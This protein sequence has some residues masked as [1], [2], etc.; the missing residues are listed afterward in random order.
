MNTTCKRLPAQST[1]VLHL[2]I[3]ARRFY[4]ERDELDRLLR[5][6]AKVMDVLTQAL[7]KFPPLNVLDACGD[8]R[9]QRLRV[10]DYGRNNVLRLAEALVI[11]NEIDCELVASLE[12]SKCVESIA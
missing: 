3:L 11:R 4:Q 9:L 2:L 12:R 8:L 10:T 7:H 6:E 1:V 5:Y